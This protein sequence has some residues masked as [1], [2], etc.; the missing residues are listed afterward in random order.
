MQHYHFH[1]KHFLEWMI[2]AATCLQCD[3]SSSSSCQDTGQVGCDQWYVP[4]YRKKWHHKEEDYCTNKH[5]FIV[6]SCLST[7]KQREAKWESHI[8]IIHFYKDPCEHFNSLTM[9]SDQTDPAFMS[10]ALLTFSPL[11]SLACRIW[12]SHCSWLAGSVEFTINQ[13]FSRAQKFMLS[14]TTL[15]PGWISTV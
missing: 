3:S 12:T 8:V 1:S 9:L 6:I 2:N 5:I 11:S 15:R 10:A 7:S 14:E 13:K 4:A